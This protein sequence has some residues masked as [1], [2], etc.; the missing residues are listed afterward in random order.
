[1]R[2]TVETLN[3]AVGAEIEAL[4]RDMRA[5]LARLIGVIQGFASKPCRAIA[6]SIS[7]ENYGNCG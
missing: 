1:M 3:A 6:S 7:T 2:W 5:R 4:P